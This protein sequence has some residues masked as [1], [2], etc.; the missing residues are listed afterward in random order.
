MSTN[1]QRILWVSF[2]FYTCLVAV[3][4]IISCFFPKGQNIYVGNKYALNNSLM[5]VDKKGKK[6][7]MAKE[8][9]S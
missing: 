1:V 7:S 2:S 4:D 9:V 6:I 5:N 3:N 8:Y